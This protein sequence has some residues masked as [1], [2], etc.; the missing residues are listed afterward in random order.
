MSAAR[1]QSPAPKKKK[2]P[3][4]QARATQCGKRLPWMGQFLKT[5]REGTWTVRTA[6]FVILLPKSSMLLR[7]QG[8][9]S[10]SEENGCKR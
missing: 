4:G 8:G 1:R 2:E 9:D 5:V 3:T 7:T 6:C 10:R